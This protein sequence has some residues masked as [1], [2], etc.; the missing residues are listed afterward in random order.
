M[1][2]D[3]QDWYT[4]LLRKQVEEEIQFLVTNGHEE[5]PIRT[6]CIFCHHH[7][8]G[9]M[10]CYRLNE[11]RRF[12]SQ[13]MQHINHKHILPDVPKHRHKIGTPKDVI[14]EAIKQ[15]G[16]EQSLQVTPEPFEQIFG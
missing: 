8:R 11:L 7:P 14:Q 1:R 3:F 2:N 5:T 10:Q 16:W 6:P 12:H 4:A 13:I 15:L 9:H